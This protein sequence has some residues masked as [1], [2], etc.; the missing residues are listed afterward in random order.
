MQKNQDALAHTLRTLALCFLVAMLEGHNLQSTGIAASRMGA[1]LH[2]S[3]S[4]LG[5]VFAIG[6]LGLF[7]GA[8]LGGRLADRIGRKRVLLAATLLFGLFSILT[9]RVES[10]GMLMTARFLT[11]VG[12]GAALPNLIALAAESVLLTHRSRAVAFMYAGVPLGGVV[13]A[14]TSNAVA[15]PEG[16]RAIFLVGGAAS[17]VLLPLMALLMPESRAFLRDRGEPAAARHSLGYVLFGEGRTAITIGLWVSYFFT[18]AV[19]YLLLNWLPSLLEERGLTRPETGLVQIMFNIGASLGSLG[20]GWMLDRGVKRVA[21]VLMYAGVV[22][23][24]F[25]LAFTAGFAGLQVAGFAAGLFAVGGQL[26]L[27]ALAPSFYA[28]AIRGSGVG[29]AVAAGRLGA[30]AGPL[31]AGA[32]LSAG[33]NGNTVLFATIPGL[34]LAG[35][36]AVTLV[37]KR[38]SN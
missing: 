34:A 10:V 29:A 24:L 22:L 11:G 12:L 19:V 32:I 8:V 2:I 4:L 26:V 37:I 17:L 6:S 7:P 1:S 33:M 9:A 36:A 15:G 27:Y 14:L 30:V 21:V 5:T 35:V 31:A 28:S 38:D 13:A 23:S 25:G 3:K 20:F 18:L 16:W